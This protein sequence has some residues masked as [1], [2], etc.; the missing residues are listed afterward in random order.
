[1][2]KLMIRE[3]HPDVGVGPSQPWLSTGWYIIPASS[4]K[5]KPMLVWQIDIFG[6][7]GAFSPKE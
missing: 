7:F 6:I 2:G 4:K 1:M 3:N 5:H